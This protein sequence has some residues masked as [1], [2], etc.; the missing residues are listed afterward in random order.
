MDSESQTSAQS[1]AA[2]DGGEGMGEPG[3]G[4]TVSLSLAS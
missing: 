2:Q 4:A 1:A 3:L